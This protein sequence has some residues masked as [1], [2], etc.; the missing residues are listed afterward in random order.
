LSRQD[1]VLDRPEYVP[2]PI[3]ITKEIK[4]T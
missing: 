1:V 2:V 3:A 4:I